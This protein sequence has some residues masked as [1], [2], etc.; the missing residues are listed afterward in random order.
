[1][2]E[3]EKSS[4][5]LP[6]LL[7]GGAAAVYYLMND[8]KKAEAAPPRTLPKTQPV[9]KFPANV[10]T[11]M[12]VPGLG[13]F[14]IN[15]APKEQLPHEGGPMKLT[16]PAT[17]KQGKL[18]RGRIQLKG[19]EKAFAGQGAVSDA[20]KDIGF[21]NVRALTFDEMLHEGGWPTT[22]IDDGGAWYVEGVWGK[23]DETRGNPAPDKLQEA[24]EL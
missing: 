8:A 13:D 24:W 21:T 7:I 3:E 5:M 22:Q 15:I 4:L 16:W 19:M 9:T 17:L 6:L 2:S 23:P 11:T 20:F 14:P 18:Y 10:P 12:H 1:M